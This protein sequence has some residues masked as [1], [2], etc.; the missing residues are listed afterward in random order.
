MFNTTTTELSTARLATTLFRWAWDSS[1]YVSLMWPCHL[2]L[3]MQI[4]LMSS[5]RQIRH[6]TS[7]STYNIFTSRS[8]TFWRNQMP[9]TSN[10]MINIERH[11]S[12]RWATKSGC[13]YK[14]NTLPEPIGNSDHSDMVLTPL[15]RLW[16]TMHLILAFPHSLARTQCSMWISFNHTSYHC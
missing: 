11:T 5:L 2:Q 8:M 7:M 13:I 1:H 16:E 3:F 9:R 10:N 14:R 6:T 15:P 4:L 12:L